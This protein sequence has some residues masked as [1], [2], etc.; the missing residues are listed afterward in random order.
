MENKKVGWL[1]LGIAVVMGIV[2]WIFNQSL[3][4]II[5]QTCLEGPSCIMHQ[6]SNTQL[7]LSLAIVLVIAVIGL[8]I[9]FSKPDERIVIKKIKGKE[10]K[11]VF[12]LSKLDKDEKNVVEILI[13]EEN[14]MFQKDLMEKLEI[15]KVKMTRLLDK[16]EAKQFIIR[17]RRG[18][19]N[20]VVL[21]EE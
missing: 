5:A 14:A 6:T 21:K 12:D 3:N 15:G 1:I 18:M 9:M 2:S 20:L 10:K 16:L 7:A 17:K 4:S 8:Y 19:N 11:K 13:N